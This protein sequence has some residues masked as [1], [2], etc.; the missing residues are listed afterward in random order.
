MCGHECS[1]SPCATFPHKFSFFPVAR[2]LRRATS[3]LCEGRFRH[4]R[5]DR[6]GARKNSKSAGS[7]LQHSAPQEWNAIGWGC[8]S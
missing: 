2:V 1:D 5:R 8:S 3:G 4:C 7:S 6:S